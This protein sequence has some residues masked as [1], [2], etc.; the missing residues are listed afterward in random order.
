MDLLVEGEEGDEG[1]G[2]GGDGERG[3]A[4]GVGAMVRGFAGEFG[5]W[6]FC[7]CF[8]QLDWLVDGEEESEE[9]EG[10][11]PFVHLGVV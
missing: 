10:K 2:S 7:C 11:S 8:C 6:V 9:T 4:E 3:V 1:V 5:M